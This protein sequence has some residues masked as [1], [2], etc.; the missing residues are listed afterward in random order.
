MPNS[1]RR[2]SAVGVAP[3]EL[4]DAVRSERRRCPWVREPAHASAGMRDKPE[5]TMTGYVR[6]NFCDHIRNSRFE[7]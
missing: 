1:R 7:S 5:A 4:F 3:E 2:P 6:P